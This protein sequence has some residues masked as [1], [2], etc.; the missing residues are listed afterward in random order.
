MAHSPCFFCLP[1]LI[2]L[3]SPFYPLLLIWNPPSCDRIRPPRSQVACKLTS[4][5]P[6]LSPNPAP[7]KFP[8]PRSPSAS[9][10]RP[11]DSGV[12]C[13]EHPWKSFHGS[14]ATFHV[15]VKIIPCTPME[16]IPHKYGTHSI[17]PWKSS[18]GNGSEGYGNC[19]CIEVIISIDA[20]N[21]CFLSIQWKKISFG[22]WKLFHGRLWFQELFCS[23][24]KSRSR[25]WLI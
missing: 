25:S 11:Q 16:I 18:E 19:N 7:S 17:D 5:F 4:P 1:L 9:L 2:P 23:V 21:F 12:F 3:C 6:T 10:R 8:E 13:P 14:M 15:L 24:V 22:T 20:W